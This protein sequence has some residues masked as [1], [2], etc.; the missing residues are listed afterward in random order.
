MSTK[1]AMFYINALNFYLSFLIV[2]LLNLLI[3]YCLWY[4]LAYNKNVGGVYE[5]LFIYCFICNI[6]CSFL[7]WHSVFL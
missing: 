7:I 1:L 5:T 2:F 3:F 4:N 6:T